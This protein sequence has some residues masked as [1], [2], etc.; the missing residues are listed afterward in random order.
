[1][2]R[3]LDEELDQR[4]RAAFHAHLDNVPDAADQW[5]RL[6]RTD[7]ML[8]AAATINA[9]DRFADRVLAALSKRLPSGFDHQRGA[10]F[11]LGL[12]T[13]MVVSVLLLTGTALG[14]I[15]LWTSGTISSAVVS[16]RA[17]I[18]QVWTSIQ[19]TFTHITNA[20]ILA[21][22]AILVTIGAI[23]LAKVAMMPSPIETYQIPVQFN[24]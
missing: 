18:G 13:W 14:L 1:M 16:I 2:N 15:Q 5:T 7:Q 8:S 24:L 23:G 12:Y 19:N 6:R 20:P 9:P 11:A 17:G 22:M 10:G 21:L 3:A 4:E